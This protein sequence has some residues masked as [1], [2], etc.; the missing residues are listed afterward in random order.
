[1]NSEASVHT[2]VRY[3]LVEESGRGEDRGRPILY[4]TTQDFLQHFRI[5]SLSDLRPLETGEPENL[6][7]AP[8][9]DDS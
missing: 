4:S 6:P 3:G 7:L 1:V 2:L 5:G 9:G 8:P